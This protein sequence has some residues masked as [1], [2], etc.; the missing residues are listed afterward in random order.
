[1]G[2]EIVIK[3]SSLRLDEIGGLYGETCRRFFATACTD[4]GG[5]HIKEESNFRRSESRRRCP[6]DR[7]P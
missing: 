4:G 5:H 6:K 2:D 1:M 3:S 7:G